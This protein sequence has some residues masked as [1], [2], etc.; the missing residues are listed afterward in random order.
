MHI[1]YLDAG[2]GGTDSGAVGN[3]LKEKD[4][5]LEVT[6]AVGERLIAHGFGVRYSRTNDSYVGDASERGKKAGQSKA[7]FALSI[8]VNSGSGKGAELLV[9]CGETYGAIEAAMVEEFKKL[10]TWRAVKSR[11]YATGNFEVRTLNGNNLSK[12]KYNKDYYG[13]I[14]GAWQYGVS[15][16]IIELFFIDNL[17]DVN[18]YNANK[19]K[20]VEAIVKAICEGFK[21]T[22][23]PPRVKLPDA[24]QSVPAGQKTMFQVVCGSYEDKANA[25]KIK[26]QLEEKGFTGVFLQ[27]V[28]R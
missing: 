26:K 23:E 21:V 28:K 25:E 15:A 12:S 27:A 10:N 9:P 16:D 13:F 14:R 3:G 8:H 7:H 5:T 19:G 20:Y 22:Y 11:D 24:T 2:H 17:S 4:I 6:K 18:T 1:V